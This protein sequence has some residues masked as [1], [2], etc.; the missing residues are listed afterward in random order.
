MVTPALAA[1]PR[2]TLAA[3]FR[4]YLGVGLTAFGMAVL[5]KLR[6]LVIGRGWLTEAET[7]EGLAL[8][9]LYP[10]P[11]M[12]D[13]TAYAGYRVRGV[14]GAIASTTGFVLPSF[15]L[16]VALSA[17]YFAAGNLPWVASLLL[18]LEA[19]VVGVLVNVLLEL[20]TRSVTGRLTA[21]IALLAFVASLHATN[22]ILIVLG[23]LIIGALAGRPAPGA[24]RPSDAAGAPAA[25]HAPPGR[26][27]WAA[28]AAVAA[29][30][31]AVAGLTWALASP[32][33][34]VAL[35]MFNVGAVAFG[36]GATIMPLLQAEVVDAHG[37]LTLR[38]FAD[39]VALGQVTPGPFLITAAFVGFKVGGLAGATLATFG[40]F[41]PS[42]AMTLIFTEVFGRVRDLRPV[43]GAL[44]G[45]LASFVGLL[46]AVTLQLGQ[47]A[48]TSLA[49]LALG[50]A[51]FVA[52]R[53]FKLDLL[54]V[55]VGGV[56]VW[57]IL[58]LAGLT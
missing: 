55:F 24:A 10:G 40:I 25:D 34:A 5:Q 35:S 15:I 30:V 46:A 44:A 28:I 38:Q 50:A 49:A 42:F 4:A 27:R 45:V 33:G 22:A 29:A 21:A 31:L 3:I 47:V 11:I 2:V 17:A 52:V 19:L 48:L 1:R 16:M 53:F 54:L 37:W 32:V 26:R 58:L 57:G 41:S 18:G 6:G 43:R 23:A 9:Q 36:N 7:S 56:A 39:G 8:V 51:A 14:P 13:F 20:A 12:V